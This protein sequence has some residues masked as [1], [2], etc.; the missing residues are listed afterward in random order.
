M[1]INLWI[2]EAQYHKFFLIEHFY[3]AGIKFL[4]F[5]I[6]TT[7]IMDIVFLALKLASTHEPQ[8]TI[9]V[10]TA[11]KGWRVKRRPWCPIDM[12]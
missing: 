12:S 9:D 3:I 5:L 11:K 2:N 7:K 4:F 10:K 6:S 8:Q 1:I